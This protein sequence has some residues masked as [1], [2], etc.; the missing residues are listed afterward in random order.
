MSDK[1]PDCYCNARRDH[2]DRCYEHQRDLAHGRKEG[3]AQLLNEICAWL[4]TDPARNLGNI[5]TA[6]DIRA[7]FGKAE[8][9]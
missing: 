5:A 9:V 6:S 1:H 2:S 3:R 8:D 4:E 7:K